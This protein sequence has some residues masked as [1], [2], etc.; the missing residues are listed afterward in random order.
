MSA[1]LKSS[2][3]MGMSLV[4][5]QLFDLLEVM[6][7][8]ADND[9]G[10][11]QV[12]TLKK[13]EQALQAGRTEDAGRLIREVEGALD[14][15]ASDREAASAMKAQERQAKRRGVPTAQATDGPATRDG[16]VWLALKGRLTRNRYDAGQ[17]YS[18]LYAKARSD[19]IRSALNDDVGGAP[20]DGPT[21]ARLR[22][23]FELDAA[24][25]HIYRA[26]GE[27]QGR[28]LV[29][30]LENVCGRGETLREIAGGDDRKALALEVDLM[31]A[32]DMEAVHFRLAS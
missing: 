5:R 32:L 28:R 21:D 14:Q 26:M 15:R 30:L 31:T 2:P 13:A 19:S 20:G 6:R 29:N 16:F 9:Q 7:I 1:V 25:L 10:C 12:P 23:V 4:K 8:R 3:V 17:R 27:E 24:N 22:A 18:T 11:G